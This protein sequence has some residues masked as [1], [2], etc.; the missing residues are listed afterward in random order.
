MNLRKL[1][2]VATTAIVMSSSVLALSSPAE[3]WCRWGC[4]WGFRGPGPVVAGAVVAGAIVGS[5]VVAASGPGYGYG[6]APVCPAG[7]H[8]GPAGRRCRPN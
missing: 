2:F 7:Y 8:L 5:A 6:P 4:G 1:G 3:A